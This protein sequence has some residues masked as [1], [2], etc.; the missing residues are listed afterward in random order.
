MDSLFRVRTAGSIDG[1]VHQGKLHVPGDLQARIADPGA[2]TLGLSPTHGLAISD[3]PVHHRDPFD[4]LTIAQAM[5]EGLT[6]V[7]ADTRFAAY[8]IEL[9][10]A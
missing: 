10:E 2:R 6:V 8:G 3:L 7:T 1:Q 9:L 5:L 4:R